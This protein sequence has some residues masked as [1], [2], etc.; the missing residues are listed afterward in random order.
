MVVQRS[1]YLG[2][3]S[4]KYQPREV[5]NFMN[6]VIGAAQ[7]NSFLEDNP[8]V[9]LKKGVVILWH[10]DL[11]SSVIDPRYTFCYHAESPT[12]S[13]CFS[14]E[15]DNDFFKALE[16]RVIEADKKR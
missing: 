2:V 12:V 5:V 10:Y 9:F 4:D 11:K 13:V 1:K 3:V 6:K 16:Q 7:V 15:S 8:L 14:S